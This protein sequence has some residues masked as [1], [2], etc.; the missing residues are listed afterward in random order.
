MP[1]QSLAFRLLAALVIALSI[2]ALAPV[3]PVRVGPQETR[4]GLWLVGMGALAALSSGGA[5][6]AATGYITI[7]SAATLIVP[8]IVT[9]PALR[10]LTY[11]AVAALMIIAALGFSFARTS[12]PSVTKTG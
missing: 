9:D 10:P 3:V 6:V 7:L 8:D 12:R 1:Y 5:I 2:E 11:G 4:L